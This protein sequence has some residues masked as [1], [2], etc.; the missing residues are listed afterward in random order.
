VIDPTLLRENPDL[1]R[2]SLRARG[3]DESGVQAALDADERRRQAIA[4]FE[5][6]RAEQ[7]AHGKL[8][9]KAPKE[10]KAALVAQAKDLADEV[11]T[12]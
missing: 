11:K 3:D 9:A 10:E 6:L 5:S 7:N 2:A 8:V 1:I 12:A 4:Q